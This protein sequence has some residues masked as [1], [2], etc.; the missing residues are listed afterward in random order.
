M[1]TVHVDIDNQ[2]V[3]MSGVVALNAI[4]VGPK[5]GGTHP[6]T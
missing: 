4:G 2:R 1:Y 6:S 3:V 5:R